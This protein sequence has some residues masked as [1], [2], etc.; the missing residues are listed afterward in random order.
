VSKQSYIYVIAFDSGTLKVGR[1][2]DGARRLATH[3]REASR[4]GVAVVSEWCSP[5]CGG[6]A[7]AF[8]ERELIAFCETRGTRRAGTEYFTGL[9][10]SE[11][12][13][14]AKELVD[15]GP[16]YLANKVARSTPRPTGGRRIGRLTVRTSPGV[17]QD[18]AREELRARMPT[19]DEA[20]LLGLSAG[21]PVMEVV[22]VVRAPDGRV[23]EYACG[24]HPA[25][26]FV[27]SY[28][29]KIPD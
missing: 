2:A 22:R 21:E 15:A 5:P 3:R 16:R 24:V 7:T 4:H 8:Y 18:E 1:A 28:T 29:F 23:I 19:R 20:V 13:K 10:F 17:V 14:L 12:R 25:S 6:R 9:D 27:W 26:R 11:V